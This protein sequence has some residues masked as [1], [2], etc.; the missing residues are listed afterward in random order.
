[1]I[2]AV[3]FDWGNV[4]MR[5]MDIRPRLAWEHHLG[6]APG[7]LADLFFRGEGW[8]A[9]QRGQI[10]LESAWEGV[11]RHLGLQDGDAAALK[12]DFWAGDY[13]DRDLVDLIRDLREQ[14]LR[15]ALLSNH[16]SNLPDLLR[17]LDLEA[18]FDVVVVSAL[19]KMVKPNPAIYQRVLDRLGVTPEEAVFVDDQQANVEAAQRAGMVG[20]RFKGCRHL[21]RQLAA[22]GLPVPVP[23]LTPVP[24]LRA[25]IFDWGGVFSPLTFL[26]RTREW[27]VRLGLAEGTLKRILWGREWKQ[28]ETGA[29]SQEAFD[30]HVARGLGLPGRE[31]VRQFYA[32]YYADQQ[33]EPRLV[34]TVRALRRRYRVALLTNAYPDHAREVKERYDFDPRTEFDLYVNSA[35]L[36]VAKPEP[37]IY[38]YV[39]D[40]LE[41]R[42]GEAVFLDDLVRNTDPARLMGIHTIVFTDVET[43]LADLSALLGHPLTR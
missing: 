5:T 25:V 23:P 12:R 14:G 13:L 24:G 38:R 37:A 11:I 4:L 27:E 9:A 15:T 29:L 17:E 34:E 30:E 19:E 7:D 2:R 8:E 39:L 42:S 3:V 31:A 10:T 16:A 26:R 43:G 35:E 21:R 6:L 36:G 28:L 40:R 22:L 32:E 18:L 33:I 41:V 20:L 1:M